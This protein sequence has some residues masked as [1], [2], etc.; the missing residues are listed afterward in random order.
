VAMDSAMDHHL[1]C[2][3]TTGMCEHN[4]S[5]P[6]IPA[7]SQEFYVRFGQMTCG[8]GMGVTSR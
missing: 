7:S 2:G 3:S 6:V 4:S 5:L 8:A 1:A